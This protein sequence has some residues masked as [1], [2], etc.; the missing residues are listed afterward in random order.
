MRAAIHRENMLD[1]QKEEQRRREFLRG[2]PG[3]PIPDK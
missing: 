2:A 1:K 3:D